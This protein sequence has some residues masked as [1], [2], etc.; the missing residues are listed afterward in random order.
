M[1][2]MARRL[3]YLELAVRE[4]LMHI[5]SH[6]NRSDQVFIALQDQRSSLHSGQ[7]PPGYRK[8]MSRVRNVARK[9]GRCG[10][11]WPPT[12]QSVPETCPLP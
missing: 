9:G 7:D 5:F 2:A 10:K 1:W 4:A 11:S 6:L 3:H 12:H 8:E